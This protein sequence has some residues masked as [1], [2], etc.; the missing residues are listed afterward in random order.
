TSL[1]VLALPLGAAPEKLSALDAQLLLERLK[2]LREGSEERVAARYKTA[3]DAFRS[4][5]QTDAAAHDLYLSCVEKVQFEDQ[6]KK[7]S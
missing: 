6:K 1:V 7:A 2:E 4:A 5:I 3:H